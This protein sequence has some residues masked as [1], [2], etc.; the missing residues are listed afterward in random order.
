M[1]AKVVAVV[2][3]VDAEG[4]VVGYHPVVVAVVVAV[5]VVVVVAVVAEEI[6]LLCY[7]TVQTGRSILK[8]ELNKVSKFPS[9]L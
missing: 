9:K 8:K 3:A 5:V 7:K 6:H 2:S 4:H 1:T